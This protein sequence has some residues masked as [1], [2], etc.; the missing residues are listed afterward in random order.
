MPKLEKNNFEIIK[1]KQ[2]LEYKIMLNK[3]G[4]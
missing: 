1:I 3:K 2:T 4:K